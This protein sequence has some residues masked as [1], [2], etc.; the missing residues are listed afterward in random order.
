MRPLATLGVTILRRGAKEW[1]FRLATAK[2]DTV[3]PDGPYLRAINS[4]ETTRR[5]S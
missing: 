3:R 4:P 5:W 1:P 2:K